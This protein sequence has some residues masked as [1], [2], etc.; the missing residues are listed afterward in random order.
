M[1]GDYRGVP[2]HIGRGWHDG[3]IPGPG[4][5]SLNGIFATNPIRRAAT[6]IAVCVAVIAVVVLLLQGGGT[7]GSGVLLMAAALACAI[8]L[9]AVPLL[10]WSI[11]AEVDRRY[12]RR[13]S[14]DLADLHLSTRTENIL[15]RAGH[16]TVA[17]IV[18]LDDDQ[19]LG[20]PRMED[21]DVRQIRRALSLQAYRQWQESGFSIR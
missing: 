2:P 1:R 15:R 6:L 13:T 20:L 19:L 21:H 10:V 18:S 7:R 8:L 9:L 17:D 4:E 14:P 16:E 11:V 12:R 5:P 3:R